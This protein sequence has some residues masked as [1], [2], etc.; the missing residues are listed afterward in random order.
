MNQRPDELPRFASNNVVDPISG[1][2]N[3]LEPPEEK[4]DTGW[5]RLEFPPRNWFNWLHRKTFEWLRYLDE[6]QEWDRTTDGN[7]VGLFPFDDALII[8]SAV[9]TA[10]PANYLLAVGFKAQGQTPVLNIISN[11]VLEPGTA[12]TIGDQEID[13]GTATNIIANGRSKLIV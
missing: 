4:K 6:R 7:G 13:G 12:T 1:Q 11:N 9:D 10:T 2:P 8:L 3:V 5:D